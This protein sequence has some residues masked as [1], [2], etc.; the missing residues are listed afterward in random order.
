[1]ANRQLSERLNKELDVIGVPSPSA[2][3]VKI[4]AKLFKLPKFKAEALL[5]GLLT[6]SKIVD[7]IAEELEINPQ[8]LIGNS[9][10]RQK[11]H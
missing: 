11:L 1:M 7:D 10:H 5:N 4:V 2:E 6:D 8:W 3:R 9:Q